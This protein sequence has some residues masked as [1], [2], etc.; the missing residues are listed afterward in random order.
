MGNQEDPINLVCFLPSHIRSHLVYDLTP[1]LLSYQSNLLFLL[2]LLQF[3]VG[4][5]G[6]SGLFHFTMIDGQSVWTVVCPV[7]NWDSFWAH[8]IP[9]AFISILSFSRHKLIERVGIGITTISMFS[10]GMETQTTLVLGKPVQP[11]FECRVWLHS[12]C[13]GCNFLLVVLLIICLLLNILG[14]FKI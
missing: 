9:E 8:S 3:P 12:N 1:P 2:M 13:F 10:E 5:K 14:H 6:Y 11:G 7:S 4:P